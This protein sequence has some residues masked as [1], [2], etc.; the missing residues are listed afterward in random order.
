M[1][2]VVLTALVAGFVIFLSGQIR[3]AW[4]TTACEGFSAGR[5]P[6]TDY[7]EHF[8][9]SALWTLSTR[10]NFS[11]SSGTLFVAYYIYDCTFTLDTSDSSYTTG[12]GGVIQSLMWFPVPDQGT[13]CDDYI[14]PF[15][16]L[17]TVLTP[18]AGG[19]AV[20]SD[21]NLGN[22]GRTSAGI[23]IP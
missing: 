6:S 18:T 10:N 15:F 20:M 3:S 21:T 13:F 1:R 19:P 22:T 12:A 2:K 23:C 5:D 4:A 7:E 11:F 8:S 9:Q 14:G 16:D 17:V